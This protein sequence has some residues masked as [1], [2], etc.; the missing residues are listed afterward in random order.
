MSFEKELAHIKKYIGLEQLRFGDKVKVDF[1]INYSDFYLPSLTVQMLV[2][3]AIKHGITKKYGGGTLSVST[4]K[5]KNNVVITVKDD[6]V[7]FDIEKKVDKK[8]IGISS[9]KNRLT[10]FVGGTLT[11]ESKIGCGTTA[12]V[13]I[14]VKSKINKEIEK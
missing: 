6:G 5:I 1:N 13:V 2:E 10:Y 12:T 3:N 4:E 8:R 14:P 9:I 7:G 11:V